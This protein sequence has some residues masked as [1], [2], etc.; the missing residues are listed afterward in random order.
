MC[1]EVDDGWVNNVHFFLKTLPTIAKH[2]LV[3]KCILLPF[4]PMIVFELLLSWANVEDDYLIRRRNGVR[5]A[6]R[7]PFSDQAEFGFRSQKMG[8]LPPSFFF[9]NS[10]LLFYFP[11]YKKKFEVNK[12]NDLLLIWSNLSSRINFKINKMH[13]HLL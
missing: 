13:D 10:W 1:K 3:R 4:C 9:A 12:I 8:K 5:P 2:C 6:L 7:P 11:K